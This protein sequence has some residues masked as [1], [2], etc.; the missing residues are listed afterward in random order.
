VDCCYRQPGPLAPGDFER[1][2]AHLGITREEAKAYFCA[3]PG[4]LVS[5]HGEIRRI[6]TITPKKWRGR[7]VFLDAHDRCRVHDVSPAG[8]A[9]FDVHMPKEQANE[10]S[11][12]LLLAQDRN[13]AY[14]AL[15]DELPYSQS[16]PRT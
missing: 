15:R 4:G 3:S 1:I 11:L 14:Q 6:G 10:R 7:C 8:C 9:L 2:A 16:P 5:E 12:W 13:E